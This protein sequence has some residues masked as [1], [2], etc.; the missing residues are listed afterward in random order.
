MALILSEKESLGNIDSITLKDMTKLSKLEHFQLIHLDLSVKTSESKEDSD[1]NAGEFITYL[2]LIA[3]CK[4]FSFEG[5]YEAFRSEIGD[6]MDNFLDTL[7]G[8]KVF[9]S[10]MTNTESE[11]CR[12]VVAAGHREDA[13]K[14]VEEFV[15]YKVRRKDGLKYQ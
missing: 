3:E 6:Y 10:G 13:T 7:Y 4:A 9:I 2:D 5:A 15:I 14:A 11:S 12:R 8:P 1:D